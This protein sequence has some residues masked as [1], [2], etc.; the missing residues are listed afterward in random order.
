MEKVYIIILMYCDGGSHD[1]EFKVARSKE[2]AKKILHNWALEEEQLTW[3]GDYE[4]GELDNYNL[5]EEYFDAL[6]GKK[7]T[8]I[9][10]EEKE[11]Q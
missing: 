4:E 2:K 6:Y 1:I 5:S 9:W 7:R 11:V 8:T 10:I 3:I